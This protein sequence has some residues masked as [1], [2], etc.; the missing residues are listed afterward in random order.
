MHTQ[1]VGNLNVL[2]V[3]RNLQHSWLLGIATSNA[4]IIVG[5][6]DDPCAKEIVTQ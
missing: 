3:L 6:L 1:T 5:I 4:Q 2:K